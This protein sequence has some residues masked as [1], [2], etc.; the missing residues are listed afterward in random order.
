M[1]IVINL[2]HAFGPDSNP[3]ESA[4]CLRRMLEL[5]VE[6]NAEYLRAHPKTKSLYRSGVS[7]GRT[8]WWEPIPALYRRGYG[9]CKSL[10][11]A[12]CAQYRLAGVRCKP[13]FRFYKEPS[14]ATKFHILVL[15]ESGW[16]DP[17]KILGM[18]A[19]EVAPFYGPSAQTM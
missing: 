6:L 19:N 10:A 8:T 5:M 12:L 18:G 17:S 2:E 14:G 7:Y 4:Q 13:V 11:P 9:D 16:E 15:T 3:V 1:Q